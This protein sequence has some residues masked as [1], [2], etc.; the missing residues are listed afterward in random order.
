V[1]DEEGEH[2]NGAGASDEE[3]LGDA[4]QEFHV[5]FHNAHDDWLD[6]AGEA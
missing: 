4:T 1:H 5:E 6:D 2:A 3:D